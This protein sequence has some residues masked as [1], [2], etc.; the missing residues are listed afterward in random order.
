MRGYYAAGSRHALEL[1]GKYRAVR[2]T[3]GLMAQ[4]ARFS[5]DNADGCPRSL[6][7]PIFDQARSFRRETLGIKFV[8]FCPSPDFIRSC[9]ADPTGESSPSDLIILKVI[10]SETCRVRTNANAFYAKS[11]NVLLTNEYAKPSPRPATAKA[12]THKIFPIN[13]RGEGSLCNITR[14]R[15]DS[16]LIVQGGSGHRGTP[17][18]SDATSKSRA[19]RNVKCE[20]GCASA[21]GA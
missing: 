4:S 3:N 21:G 9:F 13:K 15:K 11:R 16:L 14:E 7:A 20:M 2:R 19:S 1:N 5:T 12:R 8:L 17:M 6:L 10:F 18:L